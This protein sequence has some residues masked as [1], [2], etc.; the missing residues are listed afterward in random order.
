MKEADTKL[1]KSCYTQDQRTYMPKPSGW[2]NYE[3]YTLTKAGKP[4]KVK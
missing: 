3:T 2:D 4:K 1:R